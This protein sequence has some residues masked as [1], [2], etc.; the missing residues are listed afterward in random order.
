[1]GKAVSG[2]FHSPGVFHFDAAMGG[3]GSYLPKLWNVFMV[4]YSFLGL[5]R[6]LENLLVQGI[7]SSVEPQLLS[8]ILEH[9][10]LVRQH[11]CGGLH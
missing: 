5:G 4:D 2:S 10:D 1:M 11:H 7:W 6:V 9:V 8:N 3:G